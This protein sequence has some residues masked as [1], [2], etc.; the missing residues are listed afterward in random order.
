MIRRNWQQ[1]LVGPHSLVRLAAAVFLLSQLAA[2][3]E[4]ALRRFDYTETHM[5]MPVKL[6]LYAADE[7]TANLDSHHGAETMRLL[8]RLAKQEGTTVV[9]VS[10]DERLR[11]VADRVLWLDDGRLKSLAALVRDPVCG[12]LVD[13]AQ[14]VPL[15]EGGRDLFFC[16]VGCR[17]DYLRSLDASTGR[18]LAQ[19][20]V[21]R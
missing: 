4:P 16:A 6:V 8:R 17:D 14:A 10:H 18:P 5:G 1:R 2:A 19:S 9:I 3:D 7:P 13:P 12:M 20:E 11:E 15:S 21:V